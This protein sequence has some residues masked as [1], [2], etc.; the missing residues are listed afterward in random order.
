LAVRKN[1]PAYPS[2]IIAKKQIEINDK[3]RQKNI[4]VK[5]FHHKL[6]SIDLP[7]REQ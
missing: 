5:Y 3:Y 6:W 4:A 2:T 1:A 7:L